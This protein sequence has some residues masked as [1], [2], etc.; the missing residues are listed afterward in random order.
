KL[1]FDNVTA[2]VQ[3]VFDWLKAR[4]DVGQIGVVGFCMGG[5]LAFLTA[6]AVD[7]KAA[8][9]FYGGGLVPGP[10]NPY[11]PPSGLDVASRLKCP[12]ISFWGG[13]DK[14]IPR[15]HV[16]Q[17][18]EAADQGPYPLEVHWY[19]QADHGFCCDDRASYHADACRDAW[20]KLIAFL[21]TQLA[22]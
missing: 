9:V 12:V 2:D 13:Q 4:P 7:F 20:A 18:E 11:P 22:T 14:H 16:R 8:G 6:S 15:E 5:R 10:G 1:T 17:L 3:R 21:K 19:E